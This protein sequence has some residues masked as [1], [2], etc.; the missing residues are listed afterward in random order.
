ML[1]MAVLRPQQRVGWL[2][3]LQRRGNEHN[4]FNEYIFAIHSDRLTAEARFAV[5]WVLS[6]A[7]THILPAQL[8]SDNEG[9]TGNT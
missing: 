1:G 5:V 4:E 2:P 8:D 3:G 7:E 9:A 6:S